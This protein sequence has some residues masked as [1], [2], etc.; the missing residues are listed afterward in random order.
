MTPLNMK[1]IGKWLI[2]SGLIGFLASVILSFTVI[3]NLD[4][5]ALPA[6]SFLSIMLG[7]VFCFPS[8]LQEPA[9]G[10]STMRIIVFAIVMLFCVIYL[11]IGWS[12]TNFEQ[13][14]IDKTWIYILGLAFGSKVFQRYTESDGDGTTDE[15]ADDGKKPLAGDKE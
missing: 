11:K 9:G 12:I 13:F 4:Q 3:S 6:V 2:I 7:F 10:F 15:N 1:K 8:M 14:S 5:G